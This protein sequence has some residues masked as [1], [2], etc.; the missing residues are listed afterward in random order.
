MC[1]SIESAVNSLIATGNVCPCTQRT[2]IGNTT[3]G[4]SVARM[5]AAREQVQIG[6]VEVRNRIPGPHST[7]HLGPH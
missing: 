6:D 4:T 1:A 5:M 3:W 2:L 7:S